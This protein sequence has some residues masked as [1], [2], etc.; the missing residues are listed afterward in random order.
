MNEPH[1]G[2]W[3][4]DSFGV[5]ENGI[6]WDT[7]HM[8]W[9]VGAKKLGNAVLRN[10]PRLLIFVEGTAEVLT[11]WGQSFKTSRRNGLMESGLV[12]G[13]SD[14][15]K[16]VLSPHSYGP[17]LYQVPETL[18]WF[19]KRFQAREY[20]SNL[21]KY[22]EDNYG[23][24]TTVGPRYPMVMGEVGG[25]MICCNITGT[26]LRPAADAEYFA[27]LIPYL[28]AK[29]AGLYYFCLNPGSH[30]TGGI[31]EWDWRTLV[32]AKVRMLAGVRGTQVRRPPVP[33]P[34]PPNPGPPPHRTPEPPSPS[35][36]P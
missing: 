10:C 4:S 27:E 6:D 18:A 23:F 24:V 26:L 9:S 34:S 28:A 31:L 14:T 2:Y 3:G 1:N 19:P 33:P 29:A 12:P 11:E 5:D 30:D 35:P 21:R 17:A 20:P 22:W 8:D 16:L 15:S 36:A 25:D 13:L 32:H 7:K